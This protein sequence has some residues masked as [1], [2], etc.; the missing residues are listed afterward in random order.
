MLRLGSIVRVLEP[1][2]VAMKMGEGRI[3]LTLCKPTMEDRW[4]PNGDQVVVIKG[5]VIFK[6]AKR[7]SIP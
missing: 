1:N 2:N 4:F 7:R 6:D 5:D 3:F